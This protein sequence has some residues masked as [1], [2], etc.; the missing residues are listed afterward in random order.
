ML[1]KFRKSVHNYKSSAQKQ[2]CI[3]IIN[4]KNSWKGGNYFPA[5]FKN[6]QYS[7]IIS[8]NYQKMTQCID[9]IKSLSS[10]QK[11][12]TKRK[13]IIMDYLPCLCKIPAYSKFILA[14][15]TFVF[16]R[17]SKFLQALL[18]QIKIQLLNRKHFPVSQQS[19][20]L[21]KNSLS[22]VSFC[23]IVKMRN[24]VSNLVSILSRRMED[25][26]RK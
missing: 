10:S 4:S 25:I 1:Q 14:I 12:S 20:I 2:F 6:S 5:K 3:G 9:R 11:Y 8:R 16:D 18:R 17:F 26:D 19:K 7:T 24:G 21:A 13:F 15:K 23:T 22:K